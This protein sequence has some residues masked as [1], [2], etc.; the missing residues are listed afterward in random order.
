[1]KCPTKAVPL[2]VLLV[3]SLSCHSSEGDGDRNSQE[4]SIRE[5][6]YAELLNRFGRE[7]LCFLAIAQKHDSTHLLQYSDPAKDIL[8]RLKRDTASVKPVTKCSHSMDGVYDRETHRRGMILW[9]SGI[10][11]MSGNQVHVSAGYYADGLEG[12][13]GY[14]ELS[15]KSGEWIVGNWHTTAV[16]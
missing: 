13:I 5:A 8:L 10:T 16:L 12:A 6:V 11:W 4:S 3:V 1:M 15:E 9:T 2:L 14:F 7:K